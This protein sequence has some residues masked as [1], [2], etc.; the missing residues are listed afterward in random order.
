MNLS[1]QTIH[2]RLRPIQLHSQQA[3]LIAAE[4]CNPAIRANALWS[5]VG[6]VAQSVQRPGLR[7]ASCGGAHSVFA[8]SGKPSPFAGQ[9]KRP[10]THRKPDH[11]PPRSTLRYRSTH[12]DRSRWRAP[13]AWLICPQR[14]GTAGPRLAG[15]A[16]VWTL[17]NESNQSLADR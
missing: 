16:P 14:T 1:H 11:W 12:P 3:A 10:R 8:G 13:P 17:V 7:R 15:G 9:A 5:Y 6:R 4:S 2:R